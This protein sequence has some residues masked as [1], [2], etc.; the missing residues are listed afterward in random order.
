[1]SKNSSSTLTKDTQYAEEKLQQAMA[2]V[3]HR[4]RR[5]YLVAAF[6]LAIAL[7]TFLWKRHQQQQN[8]AAQSEMFQA[9]YY[10]EEDS[11]EQALQ[12]DGTY[13]GF[14]DIINEYSMTKAANLA[15]FYAG[16]CYMHQQD[17]E[18]A[19]KH[20]KQFKAADFLLQA[21]AWALIGDALTEQQAHA[22]ATTYYLKAADY[23]P[24]ESFTPT[25]LA[26]AALAYEAN[27]DYQAALH[28][29]QRIIQQYPQAALY[30]EAR[31]HAS[32]LEALL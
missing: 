9:A 19:I 28:C 27:Q 6:A 20:L 24:N 17:Y 18:A 5:L 26:K 21:R 22:K 32:R 13:A 31:K 16:V 2:Y 7:S 15:H 23:K 3:K 10:F 14:L 25:Y 1:M 8:T 30:R 29:Y 11:W 4:Q 12:G